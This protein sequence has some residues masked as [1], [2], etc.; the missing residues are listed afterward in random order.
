MDRKKFGLGRVDWVNPVSD[1]AKQW[2]SVS[3]RVDRTKPDS[4][5]IDRIDLG[6]GHNRFKLKLT[7]E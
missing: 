5:R 3:E 7:R 1:R 6:R 2:N 4:D